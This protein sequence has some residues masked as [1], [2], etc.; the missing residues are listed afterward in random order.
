MGRGRGSQSPFF[1]VGWSGVSG[2]HFEQHN[3]HLSADRWACPLKPETNLGTHSPVIHPEIR[4]KQVTFLSSPIGK[5]AAT[6]CLLSAYSDGVYLQDL[7][8]DVL[9]PLSIKTLMS[10]LLPLGSSGWASLWLKAC[11]VQLNP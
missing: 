7:T 9:G 3:P 10:L 6:W 8:L 2:N 1:P 4:L 11:G 5:T